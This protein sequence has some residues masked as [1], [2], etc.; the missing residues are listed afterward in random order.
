MNVR[1]YPP[2]FKRAYLKHLPGPAGLLGR[3]LQYSSLSLCLPT[4]DVSS[5]TGIGGVLGKVKMLRDCVRLL[6]SEILGEN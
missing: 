3:K 2:P 6:H 1:V 4:L 5:E